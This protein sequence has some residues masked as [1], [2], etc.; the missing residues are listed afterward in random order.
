VGN[1]S[2][3]GLTGPFRRVDGKSRR[4]RALPAR[5]DRAID[6]ASVS[7]GGRTRPPLT[8]LVVAG[9]ALRRAE[10]I[11]SN[12]APGATPGLPRFPD[13]L[14]HGMIII[15]HVDARMCSKSDADGE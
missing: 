8:G 13:D 2:S 10:L 7:I 1:S 9:Q 11:A 6:A 5:R 4:V 12:A 3:A 15:A 14:A